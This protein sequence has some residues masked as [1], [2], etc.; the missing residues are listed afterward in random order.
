ML[1]A[2]LLL[3]T[4]VLG[5][6]VGKWQRPCLARRA[7]LALLAVRLAGRDPVLDRGDLRLRLDDGGFP[8]PLSGE[9]HRRKGAGGGADFA[10][11]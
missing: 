11:G 4:A 7:G 2:L 6:I 9:A 8:S 3:T 1:D 5:S 10:E